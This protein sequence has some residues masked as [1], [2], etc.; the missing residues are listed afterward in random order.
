METQSPRPEADRAARMRRARRRRWLAGGASL[1]LHLAIPLV[2]LATRSD[3]PDAMADLP[4]PVVLS[5]VE[6]PPP[7][8]PTD[9]EPAAAGPPRA[10]PSPP[11]RPEPPRPAPPR[12]LRPVPVPPEVVPVV[13]PAT[14]S[15]QPVAGL[16]EAQ[17]AGA[18]TAGGGSGAG[19]GGAGAAGEGQTCD[20][21]RRLQAALREDPEVRAAAAEAQR[22]VAEAGK[23]AV[24]VWDGDWIRSGA[25]EGK[26]LAGV[27]QA[28][29]MEVGFAPEAC[30][31]EPVQG[32]VVLSMADGPGSPRLVLGS[33]RWRW[34]DLLGRRIAR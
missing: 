4:D 23:A 27:R 1:A 30:R 19:G 11:V 6:P 18:I 3:A 34:T 28:I 31:R 14:P 32:R 22:S 13:L 2:F 24:L 8:P 29:I 26:G 5:L 25:Q 7:P 10:S 15:P 9:P 12:A 33:G 16:S 21:V 17:L 20:M